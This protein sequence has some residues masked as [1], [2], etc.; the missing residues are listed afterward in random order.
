MNFLALL[1]TILVIDS[2][3]INLFFIHRFSPMIQSVQN[4]P[5]VVN[6]TYFVITYLMFALLLYIVLPKSSSIQEAFLIGFLIFAMYDF[7][8]LSTLKNWDLS[9]SIMDCVWGGVLVAL[10]YIILI[11]K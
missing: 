6:Q 11:R 5:M 3:W 10:V 8:N 1:I 2:L 9:N 7:T 4:S